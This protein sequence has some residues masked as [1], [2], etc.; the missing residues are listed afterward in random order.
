MLGP[1][2]E[3]WCGP[4]NE[5]DIVT[6]AEFATKELK[7]F[8][9]SFIQ[10][11]DGWQDGRTYNGPRRGFD[12]VKRDGPYPH[13]L[14]PVANKLGQF[15]LTTGLW[16]MPFARN[17]QDS[18]YRDRQHWFVRRP[19]GRPYETEWGGTSLDL[20]HPEVRAH[21][22]E[23]IRTIRSWGVNYFK[24]DGLWTGSATEQIYVNDGYRDDHIGNNA[25]FHDRTKTNVEVYRDGLKLL[26][27][28]AGPEVFFSGCNVSQNMRTLGGSIGLV[29]SMRI[30][31][32]NGQGWNDYNKEIKNNE[33]GSIITGPVRGTRL[34]FL[35]GRV[36]WNDPDPSYVR[37][38]IPLHHARLIT[39]WVAV[40]GA[41][42]LN[43]D[44]IPGLP[45]E[46]LDVMKRTMPAH[47]AVARPVDYF[48]SIM[49]SMWLVTD[50]RSAVRRDV[51]GLFNWEGK[52]KSLGCTTA[53][54]GL[55]PLKTYHAFDFW[56]NAPVP[57]FRGK[58]AFDVSAQSC[59]VIAVRAA[60]AHPVL[61]STSRHVTQ[62]MV[63]VT[64]EK[65]NEAAAQLTGVSRLVGDD[66]YE[67]RIAGLD[68]EGQWQLA[69]VAVSAEN[70]A[71]G[72]VI[73]PKPA[74]PGE[75]GWLRV[76]ISSKRSCAVQ[77][78]LTFKH[79]RPEPSTHDALREKALLFSG[80]NSAGVPIRAAKSTI[81]R[82]AL[83]T[84]HN[85]TWNDVAGR[86][87][88]GNGE[89]CFGA[90]GTGLQTFA[91]NSMSHWGWH[92]FPLPK[93]WT[94]DRVPSTGTF[95]KGR[96]I[97][98][99]NFPPGT[100]AIRTW[101]FD[102]PHIINLGRLRLVRRHG[103]SLT[104]SDIA[105]LRRTL[106]LWTGLQ[107]S[108]YQI[109]GQEVNAETC[110][111]PDVDLVA[112]RVESPLVANGELEAALDF[113][114][115]SLKNS[116]WVGDFTQTSG[117]ATIAT[118]QGGRRIDFNRRIDAVTYHAALVVGPGCSIRTPGTASLV[119][120]LVINGPNTG[121]ATN[122][123]T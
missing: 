79:R 112:V 53:K 36:W 38:S 123:P 85:I 121:P 93:V 32:D 24:M 76:T 58:F 92:S 10:I 101:M 11:D 14:E 19:D 13:G 120:K 17:H 119:K 29:D 69:S 45:A 54:A 116:A 89:F 44:W 110:V 26:R 23:L 40:S 122:G 18:E 111:H 55:D 65:W 2:H 34:Y 37:R 115:P 59:R 1:R 71:A 12:R 91:G 31:P 49:P 114:Y 88:L 27:E 6:L 105:G 5:K 68:D 83:V 95:Q 39:S 62:G 72:V 87:P 16:F 61:A 33:S 15:G 67:L 106:D 8:G 96:N 73:M 80:C 51:L 117:H 60:E 35:H 63:D 113:A 41:F 81:D 77:W 74:A 42:N 50:T 108:P 94:P 66:P 90:D 78:T 64:D 99:D 97:S 4:L 28:A 57:S 48:D 70:K 22:V 20:T 30:G 104:P 75:D 103:C 7:P 47:G 100:D 109:A 82:R 118:C 98:G 107:T 46:R 43:S 9:F 52:E 3:A 56:G 86:L 102:N 25:A 84:R 21:L